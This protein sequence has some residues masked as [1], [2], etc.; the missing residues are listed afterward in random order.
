MK[1]LKS[2]IIALTLFIGCNSFAQEVKDATVE[3]AHKGE[4]W[5]LDK[6]Q[7]NL[8]NFGDDLGLDDLMALTLD[9]HSDE[10]SLLWGAQAE[11]IAD[12]DLL[13]GIPFLSC[14]IGYDYY[15]LIQT[16]HNFLLFESVSSYDGDAKK[17]IVLNKR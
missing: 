17:V 14:G 11:Q 13:L 5:Y 2:I 8:N 6:A 9:V 16:A 10:N 7:T 15:K 4:V 3:I 12:G 1:N